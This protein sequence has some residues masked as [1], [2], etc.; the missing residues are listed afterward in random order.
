MR[1]G[2]I[3]D[4]GLTAAKLSTNKDVNK[5]MRKSVDKSKGLRTENISK[6]GKR[7]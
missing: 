2:D 5:G 4:K 3:K 6:R 7:A 1:V